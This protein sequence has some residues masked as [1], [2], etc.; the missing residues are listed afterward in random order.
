MSG[1]AE[2]ETLFFSGYAKLPAGITACE[3]FS[4]VGIGVEVNSRGT[5]I[6]AECTLATS[7]GR[8]FF[9]RLVLGKNLDSDLPEIIRS[10]EAR[11]HGS[12]QKAII[13]ALKIVQEKFRVGQCK[14]ATM[15]AKGGE[16]G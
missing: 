12:A 1:P 5:I 13:T 7:V 16:T 15:E 14:T 8:R 4:V 3:L 10:V 11:Y 6:D 2:E 9:K